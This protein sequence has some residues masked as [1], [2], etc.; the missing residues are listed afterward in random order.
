V[1]LEL[2]NTV[3]TCATFVVIAATAAAAIVQLRHAQASNQI[4]AFNELRKALESTPVAAAH[5]YVDTH[6]RHDL[7]DPAFRYAIAHRS[8]RTEE[9]HVVV[10]HLLT[11]A[12][13]FETMGQ[14]VKSNLVPSELVLATWSDIIVW[15]WKQFA[16][17]TAIFRNSQDA[18]AYEN[19]EYLAVLAQ[20]WQQKHPA[21]AYPKNMP[22]VPLEYPWAQADREYEASRSASTA[23]TEVPAVSSSL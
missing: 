12:Q 6:L 18:A 16:P 21:G 4:A 20:R 17:V 8:G 11:F 13:Q 15:S 22:R 7:E 10:K 1:T 3:A 5:K 14:L 23:V 2:V 9:S 19:F